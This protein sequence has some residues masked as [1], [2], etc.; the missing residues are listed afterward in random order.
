MEPHE[1]IRYPLMTEA[2]SLMIE[3]ENKLVF[4]VDLKSNKHD[5]K[6][7]VED[8]Y[9]VEVDSVNVLITPQAEKKA[10][11]TLSP[12]YKATDVAIKLGVL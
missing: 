5:V 11:V 6:K 12:E 10:F 7:A 4:I 9:D 8:L 1:V 3:Q 2:A